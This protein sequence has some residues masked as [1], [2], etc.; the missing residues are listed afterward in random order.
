MEIT[1]S[2]NQI[3]LGDSPIYLVLFL[4]IFFSILH[5]NFLQLWTFAWSRKNS[6][7]HKTVA[8]LFAKISPLTS[9]LISFLIIS[10]T[11]DKSTYMLSF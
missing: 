9:M 2:D 6:L 7:L 4:I 11:T 1:D 3:S 8:I 5:D 10:S